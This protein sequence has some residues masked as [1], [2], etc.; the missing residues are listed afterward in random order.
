MR[1][2]NENHVEGLAVWMGKR[3]KWLQTAAVDILSMRGFPPDSDVDNW[4]NL[5]IEEVQ[6]RSVLGFKEFPSYLFKNEVERTLKLDKIEHVCGVN[7]IKDDAHLEFSKDIVIVYGQNGTGKSGFSRLLKQVCG[8]RPM[9][10]LLPNVFVEDSAQPTASIEITVNGERRSFDWPTSA[11]DLQILNYV[12]VFDSTTALSYVDS[13]NESTYEPKNLRFLSQLVEICDRVSKKLQQRQSILQRKLPSIPANYTETTAARFISGLEHDTLPEEIATICNWTPEDS[14]RLK[15]VEESLAETN[16]AKRLNETINRTKSIRLFINTVEKLKSGISEEHEAAM[17]K[18]QSEAIRTR[19]AASEDADKIFRMTALDGV[20]RESWKLLWTSARSY[21]EKMAYPG[22]NFPFLEDRALCVL[23]QQPLDDTA[24]QRLVDFEAF[25]RSDLE[26]LAMAAERR[27][28][29]LRKHLPEIPN[30]EAWLVSC[31]MVGIWEADA[32]ALFLQIQNRLVAFQ[33]GPI[34][35]VPRVEWNV[36]ENATDNSLREAVRFEEV[37]KNILKDSERDKHES[38]LRELKAKRWLF[39]NAVAIREEVDR[40]K[41]LFKLQRAEQ[42]AK[43]NALTSKKTELAKDELTRD[44]QQRFVAELERLGGHR[45]PVELHPRSAGKAKVEF[46]LFIKGAK[47]QTKASTVLSEGEN[48]VVAL[49]AFLADM[50]GSG[51]STPFIFDDPISS[52]DQEYE[53]R[54][55]LRLVELAQTRQVIIFTHRLSLI[56]LVEEAVKFWESTAGHA[57]TWDLVTIRRMG[58]AVGLIVGEDIRRQK[59]CSGFRLL[60]N[61]KVPRIQKYWREGNAE[62]HDLELKAACSDFRILVERTIE[63][64][65]LAGLV[66]RF[67]RSVQTKQIRLLAKISVADCALIEGLMT[68]YSISEHSQP[69]DLT[70]TFLPSVEELARDLDKVLEWLD[71]FSRREVVA[72]T[73]S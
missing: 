68:K 64:V 9:S 19:R 33:S 43:T 56:A 2:N 21:S 69:D 71:E 70:E 67:R 23:C 10:L 42:L 61:E 60:R 37:L 3:P 49:A 27:L 58:E 20:G 38:E 34:E 50:S 16:V 14:S 4:A 35:D 51:D 13:S 48:R 12:H 29:D 5:A 8:S 52:L 62:A 40:K 24:R 41:V 15:V 72:E 22:Q 59:P 31:E 7:A 65:M 55:V 54:V 6:G 1:T 73:P 26:A 63:K 28:D 18:A 25:V 47:R 66:E 36:I 53:E 32:K 57:P 46:T 17:R 11:E 30:R 44:Y 39:E 45:L